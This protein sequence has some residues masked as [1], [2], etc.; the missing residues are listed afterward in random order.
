MGV[1]T[2]LVKPLCILNHCTRW[3]CIGIK[4]ADLARTNREPTASLA[5]VV[6]G[7]YIE[8]AV[9]VKPA[10]SLTWY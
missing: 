5:S 4:L 8:A 6:S 10:W 7:Q 1:S 3:S 9:G 2:V